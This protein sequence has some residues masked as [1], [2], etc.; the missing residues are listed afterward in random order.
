MSECRG[1]RRERKCEE[2]PFLHALAYC[3]DCGNP[4]TFFICTK[5]VA[6]LRYSHIVDFNGKA[7]VHE[8]TETCFDPEAV[9]DIEENCCIVEEEEP[10]PEHELA[11]YI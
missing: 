11:R 5:H 10:I 1:V 9:W 7:Q 3:S 4:E 8:V 2:E 6:V